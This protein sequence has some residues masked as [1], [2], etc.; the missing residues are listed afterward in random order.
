MHD[1]TFCR[2]LWS[3]KKLALCAASASSTQL[4]AALAVSHDAFAAPLQGSADSSPVRRAEAA[5]EVLSS[6]Y[7]F[8]VAALREI[9]AAA[10]DY[11]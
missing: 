10:C 8:A 6:R 2:V 1:V 7:R 3:A 5:S 4:A 11:S 9:A